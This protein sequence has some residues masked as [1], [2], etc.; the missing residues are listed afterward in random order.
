M[1]RNGKEK[2]LMNPR[3]GRTIAGKHGYVDWYSMEDPSLCMIHWVGG[4]LDSS[5]SYLQLKF[6]DLQLIEL[7]VK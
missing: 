7:E 1:E 5:S 2:Q 3:G 6:A 4:R